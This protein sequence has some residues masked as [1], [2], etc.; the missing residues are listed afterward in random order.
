MAPRFGG[1]PMAGKGGPKPSGGLPRPPGC[2]GIIA[3][4]IGSGSGDREE[5]ISL[6]WTQI[7]LILLFLFCSLSPIFAKLKLC[8]NVLLYACNCFSFWILYLTLSLSWSVSCPMF[9]VP[10][11][12]FTIPIFRSGCNTTIPVA[13]SSPPGASCWGGGGSSWPAVSP[14]PTRN[15]SY[16]L[17]QSIILNPLTCMRF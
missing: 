13:F 7:I 6:S 15:R 14:S 12:V 4:C 17:L 3:F 5:I 11:S 16:Y 9:I 2:C 8:H 10:H 1:K